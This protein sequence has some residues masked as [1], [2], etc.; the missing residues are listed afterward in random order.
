MYGDSPWTYKD[1]YDVRAKRE[2]GYTING[3]GFWQCLQCHD[4]GFDFQGTGPHG[5]YD[6]TTNKCKICHAVHRANGAYFL[7]RSDTQDDACAY[8]HLNGAIFSRIIVYDLNPGGIYT[9]NGHTI[10]ASSII[11][12]S[13]VKQWLEDV[14]LRTVDEEGREITETVKIRRYY[15]RRNKM[16]RFARHHGQTAAAD[17]PYSKY[18]RIGPLALR[19]MNCHQPHNGI[20]LIWKPPVYPT[21]PSA[22]NP[23]NKEGYKLLRRS[24]SGSISGSTTFTASPFKTADEGMIER[25]P[26]ITGLADGVAPSAVVSVPNTTITTANTGYPKTIWTRWP[27]TEFDSMPA[28]GV[29]RN[30][31][32]VNQLTLSVWCADC[33]NLNI[34]YW[35]ET[36]PEFGGKIHGERTHPAPYAGAGERSSPVLLLPQKRHA[37]DVR[38]EGRIRSPLHEEIP[39]QF[40]I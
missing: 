6:T 34:G 31:S 20:D 32:H 8:C 29:T 26:V 24:P 25:L 7:L 5:G 10:G 19:C 23:N 21:S 37:F 22:Y 39:L 18:G 4:P 40:I 2:G 11:P 27:G 9:N 1:S 30:P 36:L 3:D 15:E 33:H 14:V 38:Q 17:A 13:S 28:Y 12:D 16:F 35:E